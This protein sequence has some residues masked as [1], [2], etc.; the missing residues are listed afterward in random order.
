M[1]DRSSASAQQASDPEVDAWD[2]GYDVE[3]E[4]RSDFV[5]GVQG[6]FMLG[7]ASG[8][9]N[10]VNKIG[11]DS[12]EVNT[13]L[14]LGGG[15]TAW[16]GGALLD[17]FVFGVGATG[18]SLSGDADVSGGGFIFRTE[19]YPLFY[20]Y[21]WG[22]D[23]GIGFNFGIGSLR[24]EQEG[25]QSADGGA[26]SITGVGAFYEAWHVGHLAFGPSF[27]YHYIFSRSMRFHASTLGMRG[28]VYGGP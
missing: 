1:T 13:G 15:G 11:I 10:S 8:Y 18:V 27:D 24:A 17:W 26:M 4:K 2:G 21:D 22:K 20:E 23:L 5:L 7:N 28:V 3:Y 6:G 9:P 25:K 16:F 14:G 12:A 19:A